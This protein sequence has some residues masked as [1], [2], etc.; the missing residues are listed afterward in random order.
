MDLNLGSTK[1]KV[2]YRERRIPARLDFTG[3]GGTWRGR[4]SGR[5]KGREREKECEREREREWS[6]LKG[7]C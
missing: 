7:Q 5:E 1:T 4:K 6:I 2:L 3:D